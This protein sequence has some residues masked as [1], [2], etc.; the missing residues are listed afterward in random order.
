MIY[1]ALK[2]NPKKKAIA[3]AHVGWKGAYKKI[4]TKIIKKLIYLGSQK[5]NLIVVIGPCIAQENYEVQ[6]NF[7]IKFLNKSKNNKKYFKIIKNRIYFSL[8]DYVNGQLK[9]LRIKNIEIIKKNTYNGK[10]NF[11]SYRRS[12]KN[13][14]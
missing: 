13:D 7:R 1:K 3:I 10:N 6:N 14:N 11:F 12:K 8:R 5:K 4:V 9:N 2:N